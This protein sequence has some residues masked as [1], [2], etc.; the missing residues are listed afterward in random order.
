MQEKDAAA[1]EEIN[2]I[3]IIGK[4][5]GLHMSAPIGIPQRPR[6]ECSIVEWHS[7]HTVSIHVKRGQQGRVYHINPAAAHQRYGRMTEM[8]SVAKC[9]R[10]LFRA[11]F[12]QKQSFNGYD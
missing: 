8:E 3:L 9:A 12:E 1:A 5:G 4:P 11:D 10:E 2:R 6:L 7:D